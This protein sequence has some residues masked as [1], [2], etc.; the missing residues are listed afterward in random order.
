MVA[1]NLIR[2]EDIYAPHT[3]FFKA[4]FPS[5]LA[6]MKEKFDER[7][8]IKLERKLEPIL[9]ILQILVDEKSLKQEYAFNLASDI[10]EIIREADN[11]AQ[12]STSIDLTDLQKNVREKMHVIQISLGSYGI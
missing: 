2:K 3:G 1:D 12:V 9:C 11:H 5:Y 10:L 6:L 7:S 8:A 4:I